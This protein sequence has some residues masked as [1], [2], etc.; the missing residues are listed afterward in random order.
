MMRAGVLRIMWFA[1]R[2]AQSRSRKLLAVVTES[3]A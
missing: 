1:F 3:N 2:P